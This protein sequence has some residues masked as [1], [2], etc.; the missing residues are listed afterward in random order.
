MPSGSFIVFLDADDMMTPN[1]ISSHLAE[2]E[3]NPEAELV[4]CDDFLIDE[5]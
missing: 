2:F 5:A 3:K 1:F 4:Y